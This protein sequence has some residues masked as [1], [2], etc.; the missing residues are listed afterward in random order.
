MLAAYEACTFHVVIQ[1]LNELCTV[2]LSSLYLDVLK[3]RLYCSPAGSPARRSAQTALFLMARDLVRVMAPVLCFT[4]EEAWGHLPRL[5]TDPSSV[6]LATYPGVDEPGAVV[7]LRDA[8]QSDSAALLEKYSL[9]RDVRKGANEALEA[10]R[11]DKVIGSSTEASVVVTAPPD[12][13]AGLRAY[14]DAALADLL[15][16]SHATVQEGEGPAAYAVVRASGT[17]CER[18][19]LYRADV[20]G[21]EDHP[22][23]CAR[24]V[25]AL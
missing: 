17:K 23:L 9:L 12:V 14:G 4:A 13:A 15:I 6:H 18:C 22:T 20:G 10:A 25:E 16:V 19:W 1:S 5:S 2:D 21:S 11:R 3:D 7:A 24:C 8:V